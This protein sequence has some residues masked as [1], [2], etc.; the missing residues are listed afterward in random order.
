MP[1]RRK[2]EK[3]QQLTEFERGRIIGLWEKGFF[4][5]AANVQGSSSTVMWVWKHWTDEHGT[6]WEIVN[7]QRKVTSAC[8]NRHLLRM[9]VN[10]RTS[11]FRQLVTRF[12]VATGILISSSLICKRLL[13]RG[14]RSRVLLC[15]ILPSHQIINGC[16]CNGLISTEP[17]K[18]IC[19]K[20]SFQIDHTSVCAAL[21][22]AFMLN[23]MPVN[24]A[25]QSAFWNDIVAKVTVSGEISHHRRSN[26]LRIED[27]FNSNTSTSV[28]CYSPKSFPSFKSS[29]E[30]SYW[31]IMHAHMLQRLFQTSA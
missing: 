8:N 18:L 4:L 23:A 3:F 21:I 16:V 10:N 7:W 11:S 24:A 1:P 29:L 14:E 25:F 17:G 15:M 27:N 13:H 30:L 20:F 9:A 26:L 12:S 31:R 19:I 2:K 22:G 28:K 5:V 6:T